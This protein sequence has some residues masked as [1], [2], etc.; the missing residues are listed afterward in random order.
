MCA[1]II[2]EGEIMRVLN[3]ELQY[4]A[5]AESQQEIDLDVQQ[6]G[7][8]LLYNYKINNNAGK[9]LIVYIDVLR[10][11]K[12]ITNAAAYS[13]GLLVYSKYAADDKGFYEVTDEMIAEFARQ[14]IKIEYKYIN[15]E[16]SI[17]YDVALDKKLIDIYTAN[18]FGLRIIPHSNELCEVTNDMISSLEQRGVKIGYIYI[19]P[20]WVMKDLKN[21][22]AYIDNKVAIE[23]GL[24]SDKYTNEIGYLELTDEMIRNIE[25]QGYKIQYEPR[26]LQIGN[27]NSYKKEENENLV[28]G[29]LDNFQTKRDESERNFIDEYFKNLSDLENLKK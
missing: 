19:K 9:K 1:N 25:R 11:R 16:I 14:G 6:P 29:N 4:D 17:F 28:S 12:L 24:M 23:L 26:E 7:V 15:N 21:D 2:V 27:L 5:Q 10:N 22:K 20:L 18:L 3:G 8:D 13:L